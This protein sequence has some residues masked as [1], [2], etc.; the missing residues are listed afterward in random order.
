[1]TSSASDCGEG[2]VCD[3][4]GNE[5]NC[6]EIL[7]K[8]EPLLD[9]SICPSGTNNLEHCPRGSY[10]PDA[11]TKIPCTEGYFCPYK[12]WVEISK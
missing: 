11:V 10:C 7:A 2:L 3:G 1:M 8:W 6:T 9:G 4:R 12:V 5:S